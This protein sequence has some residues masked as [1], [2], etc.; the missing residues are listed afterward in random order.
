[1]IVLVTL[2]SYYVIIAK[3]NSVIDVAKDFLAMKVIAS[4]DDYLYSEHTKD[5]K[6]KMLIEH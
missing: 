3:S 1:M 2:V 6:L 5:N 4:F